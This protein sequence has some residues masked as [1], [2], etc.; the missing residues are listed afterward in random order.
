VTIAGAVDPA[1]IARIRGWFPP[2][3]GY[4]ELVARF[5]RIQ[6]ADGDVTTPGWEAEH[7]IVAR[8]AW[9]PKGR[10]YV[11]KA[12]WP[13]LE[14]AFLACLKL[15]DGYLIR[16]L[17]CFAPRCKRVNGDLSTHSWAI[18]VDLNAD[19]NPLRPDGV[20]ETD[21]PPAWIA[22]FEK[23]GFYWGGRFKKPDAMHLQ[24]VFNF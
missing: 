3:D 9:L 19:K 24:Y 22:E 21:I 12:I 20:L 23:R 8:A 4:A 18:A 6:V 5:G 14:D 16:T 17:G 11:N 13:M 2:P 10:L 7:M 15:E 1:V